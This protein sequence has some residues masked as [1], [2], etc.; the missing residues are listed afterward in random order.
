MK[1]VIL[2][3]SYIPWRGYFHQIRNA[4]VFIFYDD[5]AFDKDGWRNRNR[6]KTAGGT[7]WLTIPVT[8]E[9]GRQLHRTPINLVRTCQMPAWKPAHWKSLQHSYSKAPFFKKY[10][11]ML[12]QFYQ[13]ESP[14]LCEY[15]IQFTLAI[16]AELGIQHTQFRRS[17]EIGGAGAKTDRLIDILKLVGATH[18]LSGPSA[19]DY[20]EEPKFQ[21]AGISLEYMTYAYPEYDQLH[22]PFDSHVSVL[23]LL[24]MT[25]PD[26]SKYIWGSTSGPVVPS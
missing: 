6:I 16:A 23:D 17:S 2:Q 1:C 15:L 4:D 14:L 12:E 3:P 7:R 26:A 11:P 18:Y 8:A 21:E 25:G 10:A 19:R 9:A 22:P 20:L 5:V 13:H 24:F